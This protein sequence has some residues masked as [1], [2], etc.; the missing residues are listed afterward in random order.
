MITTP[1]ID[2]PFSCRYSIKVYSEELGKH[3]F[4]CNLSEEVDNKIGTKKYSLCKSIYIGKCQC[5][6]KE[7]Q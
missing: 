4:F 2:S 1:T 6:L 7:E 5:P 3:L